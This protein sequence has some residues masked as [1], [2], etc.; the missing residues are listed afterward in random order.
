MSRRIKM[1]AA[2]LAATVALVTVGVF[3]LIPDQ[4]HDQITVTAHFEDA[5]GL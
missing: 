1:I 3:A 2:E 4:A 5:V